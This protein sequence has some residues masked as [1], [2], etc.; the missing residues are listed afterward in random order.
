MRIG[1]RLASTKLA[2]LPRGGTTSRATDSKYLFRA[3]LFFH[4]VENNAPN[5][6]KETG[7]FGTLVVICPVIYAHDQS[8]SEIAIFRQ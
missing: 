4:G 2:L 6:F 8:M 7:Q 5:H 3:E 1:A